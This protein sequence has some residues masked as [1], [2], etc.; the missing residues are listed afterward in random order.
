MLVAA[1]LCSRAGRGLA[2]AR[3]RLLTATLGERSASGRM[4]LRPTIARPS[5]A[6]AGGVLALLLLISPLVAQAQQAGKAPRIG[7]LWNYSPTGASSF[8][9]AF[10]QGLGALGYVEGQTILLEE[11][12]T[13]GKLD[14]LAPLAA[15]LIR[16]NVDILVTT[17]TPAARAAQ[18][19]TRTIPIV[20]TIVSDPVESGL[21]ASLARPG[22]NITG[23]SNMHPGSVG[24]AW[25]CSRRL[26]PRSSGWPLSR[27]PPIQ[28][29]HPCCARLRPRPE[30]WDCSFKSW[31][32]ETPPA[33]TAHSRR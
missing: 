33:S 8:A 26:S 7:I 18:Q 2:F 24:S 1:Q 16:L 14:R 28:L 19:A 12:W 27:I 13:G 29:P 32:R 31:R 17:T 21:V 11:R 5:H 3:S 4:V 25:S 22:A 15:E 23:L 30:S 6:I 20:M 9:A 10:R